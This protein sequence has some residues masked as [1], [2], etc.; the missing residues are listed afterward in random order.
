MP[1]SFRLF[2]KATAVALFFLSADEIISIHEHL[3]ARMEKQTGLFENTALETRGFSWVLIYGPIA[4]AGLAV[5]GYVFFKLLSKLPESSRERRTA[6]AFL[7]SAL[8]GLPL[9]LLLEALEGY[10]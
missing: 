10:F 5:I 2:F 8:A 7:F 9:I 3:G 4:L 1:L 6:K